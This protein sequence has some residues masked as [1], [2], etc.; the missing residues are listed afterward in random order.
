MGT[1][2]V[3]FLYSSAYSG[4]FWTLT[5]THPVY[6]KVY[7]NSSLDTYAAAIADNEITEMLYGGAGN[8]LISG[9]VDADYID[10]G[11]DDDVLHGNTGNDYIFGGTGKIDKGSRLFDLETLLT[12]QQKTSNDEAWQIAA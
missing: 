3:Y 12:N 6:G 2:K 8:D 4:S 11:A 10:G 9:S 7:Y 1:D 5:G